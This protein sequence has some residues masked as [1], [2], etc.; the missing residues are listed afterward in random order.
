MT[1]QADL[2]L[3]HTAGDRMMGHARIEYA[4]MLLHEAPDV[5]GTPQPGCELTAQVQ[6]SIFLAM[7]YELR[8][9]HDQL[10]A[11]ARALAEHSAAL[12]ELSGTIR[13]GAGPVV[14]SARTELE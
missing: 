12:A 8:H 5:S 2:E 1:D 7:Y 14:P 3:Q 10:A 4:E 6:A 13:G 9:G 11:Y